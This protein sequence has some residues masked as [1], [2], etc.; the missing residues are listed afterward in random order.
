MSANL[1]VQDLF[2]L[3]LFLL[4]I[5]V[6]VYLIMILANVNKL[7][8]QARTIAESNMKEIDT[9][10]KQLPE[11]SVNINAITKEAKTTLVNLAPEVNELLH[12]VNS[13]SS[14]VENVANLIDDTTS[15]VN[16]TFDVVSDSIAETA[17]A[18]S[19]NAKNATDYMKIIKEVIE[20]IRG[21][22]NKK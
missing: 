13:I 21:I 5:G 2:K 16:E 19:Y 14:K 18:F 4:G 1:T 6:G 7:L 22:L 9:T 17:L 11:I 3:I 8:K 12:N 20:V 15:K 10:I